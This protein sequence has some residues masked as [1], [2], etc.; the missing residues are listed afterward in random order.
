MIIIVI[1]I[2]LGLFYVSVVIGAFIISYRSRIPLVDK[3]GCPVCHTAIE[4]FS[5]MICPTCG[6]DLREVGLFVPNMRRTYSYW[7]LAAIWSLFFPLHACLI[8]VILL[9]YAAPTV[10]VGSYTNSYARSSAGINAIH[11]QSE[12]RGIYWPSTHFFTGASTSK[13][14]RV[15]SGFVT[16]TIHRRG[17]YQPVGVISINA[18]THAW[19]LKTSDGSVV[20]GHHQFDLPA[21]KQCLKDMNIKKNK[22]PVWNEVVN[23]TSYMADNNEFGVL[24]DIPP[25]PGWA[26]T[27]GSYSTWDAPYSPA[28]WTCFA[29]GVIIYFLGLTII[30][31]WT[32]R[33]KQTLTTTYHS[34]TKIIDS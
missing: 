18:V 31:R 20:Q 21:V 30:Y 25:V 4:Q 33:E 3:S 27:G 13:P 5:T 19:K 8:C 15:S 10:K 23:S 22:N 6:S 1:P 11:F 24:A 2:M 9:L 16:I 14:N 34:T 32:K 12:I 7:W 17:Q 29:I 26:T 28:G